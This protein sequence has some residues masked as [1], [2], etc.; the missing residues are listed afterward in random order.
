MLS[1]SSSRRS[2]WLTAWMLGRPPSI[3]WLGS[4]V[5]SFTLH[6]DDVEHVRTDSLTELTHSEHGCWLIEARMLT[7]GSK[8]FTNGTGRWHHDSSDLIHGKTRLLTGSVDVWNL[9]G[10]FPKGFSPN[11]QKHSGCSPWRYT[12]TNH[13]T[14]TG[15]ECRWWQLMFNETSQSLIRFYWHV[16]QDDVRRIMF[17]DVCSSGMFSLNNILVLWLV[18]NGSWHRIISVH[19][20][21]RCPRLTTVGVAQNN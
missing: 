2:S 10:L 16:I 13:R 8:A 17:P 11:G 7:E 5:S 4:T 3:T 18:P 15:L 20:R 14:K 19:C 12:A 9:M 6:R 1:H 21:T